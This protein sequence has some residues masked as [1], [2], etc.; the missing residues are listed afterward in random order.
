MGKKNN[1]KNRKKAI[2]RVKNRI[3]DGKKV[4]AG[5]IAEKLGVN[6]DKLRAKKNKIASRATPARGGGGASNASSSVSSS[7]SNNTPAVSA[8]TQTSSKPASTPSGGGGGGGNKGNQGGGAPTPN[9]PKQYLSAKKY[10]GDNDPGKKLSKK[11]VKQARMAGLSMHKINKFMEGKNNTEGVKLG[12]K[13]GKYMEK[14]Q[15]QMSKSLEDYDT[16]TAGGAGFG[17]KDI[18]YL[19][20]EEGGGH[21]AKAIKD[22]MKG[23]QKDGDTNIGGK[24]QNFLGKKIQE[25]KTTKAAQTEDVKL[26]APSATGPVS[27]GSTSSGSASSG[28]GSTSAPAPAT[29]ETKAPSGNIP[30]PSLTNTMAGGSAKTIE[31]SGSNNFTNTGTFIGNNNQG[32]DFSVNIGDSSSDNMKNALKYMAI[33]TNAHQKSQAQMSGATRSAQASEAAKTLTNSEQRIANDDYI[34]RIQPQYMG[35]KA[36]QSQVELYGDTFK[37]ETPDFLMPKPPKKPKDKSK[38]IANQFIN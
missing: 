23:L 38:D 17:K 7:S 22:Y 36:T 28:S 20:S 31:Q 29:A 2:Q 21:S 26:G 34:T 16:T 18:K 4:K 15:S 32:A 9:T 5:K 30:K 35:A 27:S 37:F 24:A 33:N 11:E 6:V 3:A 10:F 14:F 8:A 1:K 25:A 19:M 12:G 13:A